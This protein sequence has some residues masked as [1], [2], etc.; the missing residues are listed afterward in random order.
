MSDAENVKLS[1]PWWSLHRQISAMFEGD[2]DV[3]VGELAEVSGSKKSCIILVNKRD[4]AAAMKAMLQTEVQI[5]G[6][7]V[8]IAVLGPDEDAIEAANGSDAQILTA[9]LTGNPRFVGITT[10]HRFMAE[11][12]YCI[13]K[14]E[15]VQFWNDDAASYKD[16]STMLAEDIARH[17]FRETQVCFCTAVE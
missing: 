16:V 1:P 17:I 6:V 15:V 13:F 11:M 8:S 5:S 4:K 10:V 2:P 7:T 14:K 12:E 3:S 9:L